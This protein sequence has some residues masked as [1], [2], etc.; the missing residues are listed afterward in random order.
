M[1]E[2]IYNTGMREF[3]FYTIEQNTYLYGEYGGDGEKVDFMTF[4]FISYF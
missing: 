1:C 4:P 2:T 3:Y